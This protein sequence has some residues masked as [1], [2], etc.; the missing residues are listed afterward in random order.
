M[1][2]LGGA[3][4]V[5]LLLGICD[6]ATAQAV[7]SKLVDAI[8]KQDETRVSGFLKT[9]EFIEPEC[10]GPTYQCKPL[11]FAVEKPSRR[12]VELLLENGANPDGVNPYAKRPLHLALEAG[13]AQN[14]LA[15][16]AHG[17]DPNLPNNWGVTPFLQACY[18]GAADVV[19]VMLEESAKKPDVNYR[20]VNTGDFSTAS[21]ITCLMQG[22]GR[23]SEEVVRLLLAKGADRALKN[24][25]GMTAADYARQFI[26]DE[27]KKRR[28]L[29]LLTEEQQAVEKLPAYEKLREKSYER[30][31]RR[32]V[33]NTRR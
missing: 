4:F 5:V 7:F 1:I 24:S 2:R 31:S 30:A 16:L 27:E 12:I 28:I 32:G 19:R 14:A 11:S 18:L 13:Q 8:N 33:D 10:L 23:G 15:L 9:G 26:G 29:E 21:G 20:S 3:F 17:A 25:A 6:F 22:A